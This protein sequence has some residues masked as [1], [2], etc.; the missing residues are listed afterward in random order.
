MHL[1]VRKIRLAISTSVP[2]RRKNGTAAG[3]HPVRQSRIF[4]ARSPLPPSHIYNVILFL[5]KKVHK[6]I[7]REAPM[8]P[9]EGEV[10]ER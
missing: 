10:V 5:D 9:L 2:A 7:R 8:P 3:W 1:P 4:T 6:R